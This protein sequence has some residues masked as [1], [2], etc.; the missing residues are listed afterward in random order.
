MELLMNQ[1][2]LLEKLN[3]NKW[4]IVGFITI[5]FFI[6]ITYTSF[7]QPNSITIATGDK[8]GNYHKLGLEVQESMEKKGI[9]VELVNTQG[10]IENLGLLKNKKVDLA[11]IQ[12]N[13]TD[14]PQEIPNLKGVASLYHEPVFV[15]YNNFRLNLLSQVKGKRISLGQKGSGTY[16]IAKNLLEMNGIKESDI[17]PFY[18]TYSQAKENLFNKN[19]DIMFLVTSADSNNVRELIEK[20][21]INLLKFENYKSYK[22]RSPKLGVISI[23]PGYYDLAENIPSYET[24]LLTT[25]ATL[26]SQKDVDPRIV[27]SLLITLKE[28]SLKGNNSLSLESEDNFPSDKFMDFPLH[29]AAEVYFRDGPSFLSKYFSY[30]VILFIS[31]LK[32]FLLPL[33]PFLVIVMRIIPSINRFR[34]NLVLKKKYKELNELEKLINDTNSEKDLKEIEL[35]LEILKKTMNEASKRIPTQ[36]Q[37]DIYDWKLHLTMLTDLLNDKIQLIKSGNLEHK[38]II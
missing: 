19:I 31:K 33:I 22:F 8:N 27:E 15:F 28:L 26:I 6:S 25:L 2:A 5:V 38:T 30:N 35:K 24:P 21:G 9:K 32:Y 20:K 13:L 23:P 29:K 14:N 7:T 11:F 12:N 10:S 37:K 16:F 17:K 36:Y 1:D 4:W 3:E 18:Y 34:L